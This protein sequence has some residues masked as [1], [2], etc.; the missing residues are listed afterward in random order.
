MG[1]SDIENIK[2][3]KKKKRRAIKIKVPSISI[4]KKSS[5]AAGLQSS[6]KVKKIIKKPGKKEPGS[7]KVPHVSLEK[8][9]SEKDSGKKTAITRIKLPLIGREEEITAVE[10][11]LEGTFKTEKE[12]A[13]PGYKRNLLKK[14][15][16]THKRGIEEYNFE[17]HGSLLDIRLEYPYESKQEYWVKSGLAKVVIAHNVKSKL[18]EYLLFEPEL[19]PF[20]YEL[21]ERI[22]EDLRDVLILTDEELGIEREK[23]LISKVTYLID[24]YGLQLEKSSLFKIEYYLIRN[25]LGW[26]RIDALMIDPLIEDISCDGDDVPIFLFHRKEQNIKTNISFDTNSL[27]SLAITLAQR[28]GKHISSANPI[29]DATMPDG[30]RLQLTFGTEVTSRGTSFTIRKFRE[31]PFTPV[32]L[33]DLHTF[34]ID[35]LVYFWLAIENNMSLVFI[36]GTASG[37]TTSLNAV[38]LFIPPLAK[39]ISI[40]DTREVT[41]FHE[42][43]IASVTREVVAEGGGAHV[44]MFML[45]KAAMR[46]R[47]EYIL[48]GEVRGHEAQT[49][50][51]AMNTGHTTFSTMHAGSV[52]AAIH[53]LENEPLN[54]PRNMLQALNI[55]SI[56]KQIQIGPDRVRRCDEIVE[57]AGI[58]PATGNIM[59]N[60]VFEY[61]PVADD[62]SYTGRSQVLGDIA[63]FHGWGPEMLVEEMDRRKQVLQSV[64]EQ[65]IRDYVNFTKVI[66]AYYIDKNN[67]IE[68][69]DDLAEL[70]A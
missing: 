36:G 61:D 14:L 63:A 17:E 42:N 30:S 47:P 69:L 44:D 6:D 64:K 11:D 1:D 24:Y 43:W 66:Q 52:D 10:K 20:E 57:I 59:V 53:R 45:L 32:D 15:S 23:L 7:I 35:M 2:E 13:E 41:L 39:V 62:F 46:Q 25:Y 19:T 9:E 18:R 68:N 29:I 60:T 40:E 55:M 8:N 38:S 26:G 34:N 27:I 3:N 33:M 65:N 37:K 22:H 58:D 12:S 21:L 70:V 67:V 49:L 50:F 28:S 5:S 16:L 48:V 56:Q 31:T 54:V 4:G 51:Q